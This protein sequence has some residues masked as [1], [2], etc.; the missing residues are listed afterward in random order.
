MPAP[1]I[2]VSGKN[3]QLGKELQD[4]ASLY[5][6]FEF[7]FFDK[8]ELNIAD[9]QLL[10]T[11]F[12]KYSPSFF[13]NCAAYTAVDK[14][15]TEQEKAYLI[16]A[17]AVGNIAKQC[18]QFNTTLI[19]ISTDYV[20]DGNGNAP[21]KE[22]DETN[23]VN[24]YGYT[25]WLGEQLALNNNPQTI[26]I[27]TSWVYS[28]YG[29]NF[30]KTMLRLMKERK[31]INVVSDQLGSPT[32]AKDL[33][34]AILE[35]VNGLESTDNSQQF[36]TYH[37]S[38]EDIISWYDFAVA[39]KE[40]KQLNCVVNPIPTSAYPTPAKRPAYSGLDKSKI[41]NTFGLQ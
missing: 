36:G 18:H 19:H 22:E 26:V 38:N 8:D 20:F 28:K 40:I 29:N 23:P 6:N 41:V 9:E 10:Q 13:I 4:I 21:Y 30:V 25:K 37:F 33:A 39:I 17:E 35:I 1:A 14:A 2:L 12:Q 31:E 3:G 27:R 16:N 15:E 5:K 24:Y 34:E 32:Y 7:I 11:I